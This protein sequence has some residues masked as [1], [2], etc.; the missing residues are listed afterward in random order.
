MS[1]EKEKRLSFKTHFIAT[2]ITI[3]VMFAIFG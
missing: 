2:V 3:I 1:E